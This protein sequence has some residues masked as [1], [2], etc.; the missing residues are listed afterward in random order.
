MT[1]PKLPISDFLSHFRSS[2]NGRRKPPAG[3][4]FVSAGWCMFFRSM[5]TDPGEFPTILGVQP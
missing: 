2:E 4:H 1:H 5:G 3:D